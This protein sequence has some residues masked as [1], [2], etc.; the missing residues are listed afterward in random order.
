MKPLLTFALACV[1]G[2]V[3]RDVRADRVVRGENSVVIAGHPEAVRLGLETLKRGGNAAD[4][5][6]TVSLALGVA[7]PGNSGPGG[8]LVLMY[9]DAKTR[10]V[11]CMVA[12]GAAPKELN[13]EK[14]KGLPVDQR[15]R[16]WQATCT[17]GLVAGLGAAHEK[18]G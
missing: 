14:A 15:K 10:K 5:L 3:A 1:L 2:L 13:A 6:V 16:G 17:P 18:W 12:L 9:Y 8:K 7:E 11:S 4:A